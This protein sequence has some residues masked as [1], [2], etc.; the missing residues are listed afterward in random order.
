MQLS[1][2][3]EFR[4]LLSAV[5]ARDIADFGSVARLDRLSG[6][7]NKESYRVVISAAGAE[8]RLLLRRSDLPQRSDGTADGVSLEDEAGVLRAA[9]SAGVP[10]PEVVC[11]LGPEDGLGDGFL[12]RWVDG[13]TLGGRIVRSPGLADV[14]PRLARQCGE[15]LARIHAVELEGG[16]LSGRLR[17]MPPETCVREVWQRYRSLGAPAPM[18]DFSARWLLDHLP[19]P[20][21]LT[22]VHGDFRNGN[23]IVTPKGIVA[24]LD[25]EL[26]HIGD[27]VRDLGWLCV[28][29]WRFGM[30]DL[31]VGGF[32]DTRELLDGYRSVSGVSVD[33]SHLRFWQVFGSFFWAV[34]CLEMAAIYRRGEDTGLERP[35]IGRRSSEA[36]MDCV[37][38]LIPGDVRAD[39]ASVR[40]ELSA[41][42]PNAVELLEPIRSFLRDEVVSATAG[43]TRYLSRVAANSVAI[44][45]RELE[46][47]P[48]LREAEHRRLEALLGAAGDLETLR[49]GLSERLW[50]ASMP[51]DRLDLRDHLRR[52]VAGQLAIDQPDYVH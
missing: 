5:L 44:V 23:L 37:D 52:T 17:T 12:M 27:P 32:G 14:R 51:L 31:P 33:E 34:L 19:A 4:C 21:R 18:I 26:A 8:T 45:Q 6:G 25:W 13:E 36:Q 41:E 50:D 46:L 28:N 47:G 11:V 24:V 1:D 2:E 16:A 38:L 49:R 22:L 40:A 39:P 43:R 29:S 20:G 15:I 10:V 35:A 9:A 42:L 3:A 48:R 7:A 30:R